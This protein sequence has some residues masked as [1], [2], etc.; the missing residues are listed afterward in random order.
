MFGADKVVEGAKTTEMGPVVSLSSLLLVEGAKDTEVGPVVSLGLLLGPEKATEVGELLSLLFWVNG[1]V[2]M[3]KA[4]EVGP[5][6]LR[7]LL[8]TEKAPEVE[9][10]GTEKLPEAGAMGRM[11][12]VGKDMMIEVKR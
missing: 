12:P 6:V 8:G 9:A 7:M 11:A 1:A 10:V 5:V 3:A 4:P 2:E